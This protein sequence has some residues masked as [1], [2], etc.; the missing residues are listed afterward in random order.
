MAGEGIKVKAFAVLRNRAGERLLVW[1]GHDPARGLTFHR[2]LGGHVEF[3]ERAVEA[4]VREI[5]EE[6]GTELLEPRLLGVLENVFTYE[7]RPG[8]E[9]VFVYDGTLADGDVVPPEGGILVEQDG[10]EVPLE[11]RPIVGADP[12]VPLFPDGVLDL[13]GAPQ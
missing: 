3:G 1:R 2:L 10:S 12:A 6:V 4:V 11:W 7:E 8:H 5:R 13:I 9:V